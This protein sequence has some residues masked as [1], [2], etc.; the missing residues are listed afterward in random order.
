MGQDNPSLI[1]VANQISALR[2]SASA[3]TDPSEVTDQ[4]I[5][6]SDGSANIIP[7][8]DDSIAFSRTFAEVLNIVYLG[9]AAGG[10]GFFPDKLNG[11]IK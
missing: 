11:P 2:N 1:T 10:Y 3:S 8:D 6:N 4:G 5:T 7:A 9:G